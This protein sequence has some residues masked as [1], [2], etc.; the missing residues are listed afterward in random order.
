MRPTAGCESMWKTGTGEAR[1]AQ[2]AREP[3]KTS[4]KMTK[5]AN[6]FVTTD[7]QP[8][9]ATPEYPNLWRAQRMH[10]E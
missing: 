1:A 3:R 7:G 5:G 10:S 2:E 9:L 8:G 4:G 6:V